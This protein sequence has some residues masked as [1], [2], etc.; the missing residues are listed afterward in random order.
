MDTPLVSVVVLN[1][2]GAD[3]LDDCLKSVLATSY[4]NF[5]TIVVDNGSTDQ[6][7]QTIGKYGKVRLVE[8]GRN[9]GYT[10]GNAAGIAVSRGKYI[11]T[12][13]NDMEVDSRW[14]T[15]VVS[16]L[17]RDESIGIAG[18]RQMNFY[19]R[20]VIDSL[21]LVPTEFLLLG[22]MGHAKAF[23]VGDPLHA[24]P[25]LVIGANGGSAVYRRKCLEEL[26]GFEN[27]FFAYHEE[28]D[29]AMRA[30][31]VGWKC[32]YVPTAVVYHKGS[33]SFGKV[34]KEFYYYHE[35]NRIWFL[36][37]NF[38]VSLVAKNLPVILGRELRTAIN[39]IR[40]GFGATYLRARIDGVRGCAPFASV[41]KRQVQRMAGLRSAYGSLLRLQKLPYEAP[42]VPGRT[43]Q[44]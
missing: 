6:S 30:F 40:H 16:Y 11:V 14:L 12:L 8:T 25:G 24:A 20:D 18:C 36:F 26:G 17:E 22:R 7:V 44:V 19:K 43:R 9:L 37:R 3:L 32:L 33:V 10:G 4:P 38:P 15:E 39:I 35:R 41:R 31:S 13:N 29:L 28:C 21:Y 34:K 5:E 23:D 2:N 42:L 27:S 1:W